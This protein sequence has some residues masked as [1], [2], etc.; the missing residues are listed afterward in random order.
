MARKLR[1]V[2]VLHTVGQGG[3]ETLTY[4]IMRHLPSE[5]FDFAA[6]SLCEA[7]TLADAMRSAGARL[8]TLGHKGGLRPGLALKIRAII[9]QEHPDIINSNH[10]GPLLYSRLAVL[11]LLRRPLHLHTVHVLPE[12]HGQ[13]GTFSKRAVQLYHFLL[14]RV[15]HVVCVSQ[16]E[17]ERLQQVP[18]LP[19]GRVT[20]I[21]NGM[22]IRSFQPAPPSA[23]LR[24]ELGISSDTRIVTNV[25]AFRAQ[26]NQIGLV[27]AFA[28]IAAQRKDVVLLLVGGATEDDSNLLAAR[29]WVESLGLEGRVRFLGPRPDVPRILALTDV[30]VQPSFYEG[31]PLSVMEAMGMQRAVVA[32]DVGGNNEL[33]LDG[34]TGLLVPP[35]DTQAISD[36]IVRLL[37]DPALRVSLGAAAREL[38]SKGYAESCMIGRYEM[39]YRMLAGGST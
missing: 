2:F 24:D 15:D 32:T 12:V 23:E 22:D 30:Y 18:G 4:R 39:L 17:R 10:I 25:G 3:S 35:G 20:A 36:A 19:P 5:D 6:I 1:I 31:L 38:V 7:G 27:E 16:A 9:R 8:Y 21:P 33:V 37:D 11:S 13:H 28:R 14:K 34:R 29:T 26:K